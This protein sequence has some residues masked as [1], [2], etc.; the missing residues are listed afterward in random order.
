MTDFRKL[1]LEQKDLITRTRRDLH[2]IPEPSYTEEKTSS[3]VADYLMKERLEVETG[4]ARFGVVGLMETGK[5]GATLMIRSDMDALPITEET[6]L[7]FASTHKNSMHACGHDGHMAM[8]L[9]AVTALNKIKN[10]LKGNIKF[11]FQPAEEGPGG[12]KPMIDAGVMENPKVDYSIG[13]HLWPDVPEG[14]I[15]VRVGRLMAAMDRFDI[16]IIGKG[17]HGAMPHMC[18]D[19]LEVGCQVIN[20]LQRIVSR[21]MNPLSPTVV[22]VAGFHAGNTFNVIPGEAD[23]CGTTR[24]FDREI[25]NSWPERIEKIVRSVCQSM[26]A[27]YELKYSRG[28]PPTINDESMVEVVRR[29]AADVVGKDQVVEPEPTMG[30]EDMAFFLERSKGCYFFLGV[31]REGCAP[32]HN[33]K[34]DFN[35]DILMTGV[36]TYCRVALELLG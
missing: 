34:F 15:G 6:G 25:W 28:Y 12:A 8:V 22:T 14:S 11:L 13:C 3:Y 36:E 35:E 7:P 26:D 2:R 4:I 23:L 32:L 16:K 18:V 19:A 24:T 31:G 9:G 20:A 27:D 33:P 5:T 1:V 21:H 17:G 29:C 30:G 10:R